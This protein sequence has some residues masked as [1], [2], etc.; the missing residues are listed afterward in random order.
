MLDIITKTLNHAGFP[1]IVANILSC[2]IIFSLIFIISYILDRFSKKVILKMIHILI[3][4]TKTT[5]DDILIEK[6]VF[7]RI[8]HFIPALFIHNIVT[9]AFPDYSEITHLVQ[10]IVM[11]YMILIG[12]RLINSIL[13]SILAIYQRWNHSNKYSITTYLQVIKII[14]YVLCAIF[15]ISTL[16]NNSPWGILSSLGAM[17]AILMLVFKDTILGFVAS[18]QLSSYNMIRI[19]DWIE[20]PKHGADG[21]VIDINL[22]TVKVQN[23]DKT[24]ST[25]PTYSLISDS[26]KNWRGMS[27][28]GGRRIKR[29]LILDMNTIHFLSSNQIEKFKKVHLLKDYIEQKENE[30]EN[31]N[32]TNQID[33]EVIINGRRLTNV[34]TFRNYIIAYLKHHPKIHQNLTFL[35]R[36]LPPTPQG[37]PLEIYVF[38]NDQV[39]ANYES[40]QADIFDHLIAVASEFDLKIFQTPSGHDIHQLLSVSQKTSN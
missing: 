9:L 3:S 29:S 18:I 32:K 30:L 33:T 14:L 24:I 5:L 12:A 10:R 6:K 31:Y 19:G 4:K 16:L 28:S 1:P 35:V 36:Q 20:M 37:L 38:S 11:A 22:N 15:M 40:I 23:W 26:F 34:G 8:S 7:D 25:I 13:D 17:T 21:D 39:W 2:F 27:E